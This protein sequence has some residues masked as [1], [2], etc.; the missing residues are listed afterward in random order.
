MIYLAVRK[1]RR[2]SQLTQEELSFKTDLSQSYISELETNSNIV[3]P[4]LS[5]IN[6]LAKAL[7][8]CPKELLHCDCAK[9]RDKK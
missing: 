2:K 7:N 3:N 4:T 9:C 6:E 8:V 1:A 5:T